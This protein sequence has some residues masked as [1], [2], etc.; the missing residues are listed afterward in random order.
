MRVRGINYDT[1]FS[2]AGRNSRQL[3][4]PTSVGREMRIIADELHCDAVRITGGDPDRLSVAAEHAG[5]VGLE[6]WFA[7]FPCEMSTDELLPYF[8]DCAERAEIVRRRGIEVVFVMGCELSMFA[9]GF[10]PGH[11]VL[12]RI[13]ALSSGSAEVLTCLTQLKTKLDDFLDDAL[14]VVRD[15]F[16]GKVT[17]AA[18]P[19]E[20]IDWTGFD[21]VAVDAYRSSQ[22]AASYRDEIRAHF[23]HDK[24]VAV[25]EFGTCAYQGAAARG[26]MAWAILDQTSEVPRL[27]EEP[28]RDEGEQVRYLN[29]V[30]AIL[31]EEG[32][33]CAFWFTF[34]AFGLPHTADP[35]DDLDLASY[36]IVKMQDHESWEPKEG[37]HVMAN[38][39]AV[40]SHVLV[41]TSSVADGAAVPDM[42]RDVDPVDHRHD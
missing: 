2:P 4:E 38:A 18:G 27:T 24:P 14:A 13:E 25:T 8:A 36:G 42:S 28:V 39:F 41:A 40:K 19:W 34:A 6:V 11:T 22:N 1:G 35:A 26:G 15:R 5:A 29:E 9:I 21:V 20:H 31:D 12:D 33:D 17:Y 37:F 3:F 23:E 7:P 32:V 16:G 30:L 10:F